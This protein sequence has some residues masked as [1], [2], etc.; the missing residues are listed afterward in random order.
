MPRSIVWARLAPPA[1][2][3]AL[4]LA[5]YFIPAVPVVYTT[6]GGQAIVGS[7]NILAPGALITETLEPERTIE[8][9]SIGIG[10]LASSVEW[11]DSSEVTITILDEAGT[12]LLSTVTPAN[13]LGD[14]IFEFPSKGLVLE[15]GRRYTFSITSSNVEGGTARVMINPDVDRNPTTESGAVVAGDLVMIINGSTR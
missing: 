11:L 6:A 9:S 2:F 13:G 3:T 14:G 4:L 15:A 10:F 8:A 1:A 7:T 12:P 5:T